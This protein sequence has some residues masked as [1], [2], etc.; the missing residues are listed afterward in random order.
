MQN[1]VD[2][3]YSLRM[4]NIVLRQCLGFFPNHPINGTARDAQRFRVFGF[5]CLSTILLTRAFSGKARQ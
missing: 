1:A 2:L 4:P 3:C 5:Y